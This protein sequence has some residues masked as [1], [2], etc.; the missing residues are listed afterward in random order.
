MF[1]LDDELLE[2]VGLAALPPAT[3]NAMLRHIYESLELRVGMVR[4]ERMSD[5]QLDEF[6]GFIN[7]GD[8]SAA[9]TWLETNF[10]DDKTVVTSDLESLRAEISASAANIIAA[11]SACDT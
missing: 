5:V 2:S 1:K 3:K 9:L 10:P 6:E 8:Q 11:E 7:V 4:A